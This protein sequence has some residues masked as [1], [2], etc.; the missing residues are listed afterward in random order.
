MCNK[1]Q[2]QNSKGLAGSQRASQQDVMNQT[3]DQKKERKK[4]KE[5]KKG[6]E[7]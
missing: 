7:E 6:K 4:R 2:R 1:H 3:I 5:E